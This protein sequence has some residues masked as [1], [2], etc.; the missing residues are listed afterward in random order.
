M[1]SPSSRCICLP[2]ARVGSLPPRSGRKAP[3]RSRS[4][5]H[6]KLFLDVST[7]QPLSDFLLAIKRCGVRCGWVRAEVSSQGVCGEGVSHRVGQC[8]HRALLKVVTAYSSGTLNG[9]W[10]T[11]SGVVGGGSAVSERLGSRTGS[12]PGRGI[13]GSRVLRAGNPLEPLQ[14]LS[15]L[16][17]RQLDSSAL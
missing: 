16:V 13:V 3:L 8:L 4:L 5:K 11:G 2:A 17:M 12:C 7:T 1:R 15:L 6:A 14:R 10:V 9:N